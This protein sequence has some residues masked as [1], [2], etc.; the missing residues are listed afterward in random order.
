[1]EEQQTANIA[2]DLIQQI[3][4]LLIQSLRRYKITNTIFRNCT[5]ETGGAIYATNPESLIISASQFLGNKALYIKELSNQFQNYGSGGAIYYTCNQYYLNCLL[6]LEGENLFKENKAS[7]Q[8]GAI[9]WDMLEPQYSQNDIKFIENS[10][11]Y[12]GDDIACF[13]QNLKGIS[14]Q[15]YINQMIRVGNQI[16]QDDILRRTLQNQSRD[17][18]QNN[19]QANVNNQRSGG[20]LPVMI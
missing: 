3:L 4:V 20:P 1:M 16:S 15:S 2:L 10:A 7:I 9:Y 5:S 6:K 14:K 18:T 11:I 17:S 13:A 12:Y 19:D 8:G